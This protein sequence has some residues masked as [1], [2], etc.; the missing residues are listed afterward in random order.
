MIPDG[1]LQSLNYP[2]G[3]FI[4]PSAPCESKLSPALWKNKKPRFQ[5]AI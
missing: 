5:R 2:S 4:F 1:E 3:L